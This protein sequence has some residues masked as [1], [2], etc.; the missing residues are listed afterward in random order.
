MSARALDG[1]Q[2]CWRRKRRLKYDRS[3]KPASR[4]IALIG[5]AAFA[6]APKP[7]FYDCIVDPDSG[8]YLSED[9]AFCRLWR[10]IGGKVFV[11]LECK[12]NHLGQHSTAATSPKVCASREGGERV[13]DFSHGGSGLSFHSSRATCL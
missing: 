4:A 6:G 9:Y 8:R 3:P 7:G 12:L 1:V 10:D 2:P 11:D 5:R 13:G